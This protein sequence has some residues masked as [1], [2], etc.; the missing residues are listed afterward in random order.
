MEFQPAQIAT[1]LEWF[2]TSP[3]AKYYEEEM[4][5]VEVIHTM[6]DEVVKEVPQAA[7]V[8][9]RMKNRYNLE[10]YKQMKEDHQLWVQKN[11][12]MIEHVKETD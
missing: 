4:A 12:Q 10:F 5:G 1:F 9:Q 7:D 8:C 2:K 6:L 3:Y 11:T